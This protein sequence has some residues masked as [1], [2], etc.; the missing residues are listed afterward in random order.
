MG[1]RKAG[2]C[3][4]NLTLCP[5]AGL[6]TQ[7][8]PGAPVGPLGTPSRTPWTLSREGKCHRMDRK[9]ARTSAKTFGSEL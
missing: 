9:R 8:V 6:L 7:G 1:S 4:S 5:H 3:R 2:D